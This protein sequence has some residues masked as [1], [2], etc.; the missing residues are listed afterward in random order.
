MS[1]FAKARDHNPSAFYE[2]TQHSNKIVHQ[3]G[4]E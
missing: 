4:I 3:V 2:S 1:V